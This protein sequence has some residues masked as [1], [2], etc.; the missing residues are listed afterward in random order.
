M[1]RIETETLLALPIPFTRWFA[2]KGWQPRAHQLEL[3]ARAEAGES[4]LLI[5]PT[6]AGKTLA[7]FLPSLTD[8][9]RRGKIP[10]GSAFSGIHTLYISPLK[11]LAVDIERNLMKP[12]EEMGLPV[13]VENRTGDTPSAKRQRQKLSP[14]DILL[15]TPEQVALLLANGQAQRFF[16]DLR[17]IVLDEL[18]SLVSSKRGHMLSLGLARLRRLAPGLQTI[19]LSAT[20]S[21]PMELQKW[22]VGQREGEDRHAG[23]VT[24]AGGAKPDISIL[25]SEERIPWAGHSAKYAIPDVYSQLLDHKTTLLFVNTR[26]QAEMLFQE[27]WTVNDDNLPIALHHGSLDVGQ[28]RKVE[29]AMAANKLRAVVATSTLDLGIDWGDVDLVIHVG[30]PKGASRLAQRIGRSNHRM[31]EPS[32]AI[33]VPANR[34]EVMECQAALDANYIG[35]QDTP[36]VGRGTLDVLAQHVL[37]MAC[38]EPFDPL[39]LF[40][41][42]TSASPYAYLSWETFEQIVDFVATGGYALR[43]YERYAR[44]RKMEDG[45]WRISNPAVAQQYRLNSGTI[46][47][48]PML[49]L[50]MVKRGAGGRIGRGGA[51]LGKME[52]Y[53]FE[54]LSPGDTFI[55]SGKVLRYE[56]IRENEA[57]AS[58][59]YSNDPKIP[60]YNGGKFPLSTYLADQVRSMLAD[61]DRWH[62]LP[63]QVRDWLALQR[64]KSMVPKRDELL[65]E[66]FP[67]GSRAYMVAYPFEGRLAHQ[68]LGML[69]TRRL[70]RAGAKPLGF[71]ATDYSLGIWG[72]EDMGQMIATGR[73]SLSTLFDEDM[74]GDDLEEWLDESFL[75]K[76]TFRNCAVISGLIERRHPGKEKSGRQV[77]VSADLIY[78]VLRSHEPDHILLQATRQDAATGLLDIARLGD[79]LRRIKGHITHRALDHISPLAVPVMLEIGRESVPGEAHDALL[80]EAADDLIAEALS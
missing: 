33:L 30:A 2:E 15:T 76:R 55:F 71:V 1:D 66:T 62:E 4:T 74:L 28:R 50:K 48:S 63:D 68:T 26:S 5:A 41:E 18:H 44:I 56:G 6:G 32:K 60:S 27:L 61:P 46:V 65:I 19:G 24:V 75:L 34:F 77:T 47:E 73:L 79:M 49:N 35:A 64:E 13:T 25:A 8:L 78:D 43:A 11:A 12:V 80:A 72:L 67:R 21:D 17:Y 51:T 70:E 7:G 39:E 14:P 38:A 57:L 22:L 36:P 54:Q 10:P 45:R 31:D 9:T 16:G 53:F 42:I 40:D 37:G 59:A 23:L 29:A 20:V 58:Q 52:E 3:L 69:L